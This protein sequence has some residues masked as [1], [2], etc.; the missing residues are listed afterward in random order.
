MYNESMLYNIPVQRG[1]PYCPFMRSMYMIPNMRMRSDDLNDELDMGFPEDID[2]NLNSDLRDDESEDGLQDNRKDNINNEIEEH[3]D[4]SSLEVN[5]DENLFR[6]PVRPDEILRMIE[7]NNPMVIRR[8][9]MHGIP[10]QSAI[11][12]VRRIIYL[13]LQYHK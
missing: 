9:V 13:S 11:N 4:D 7:R 6:S 8:L 12:M 1:V 3:P 5:Y 10:Y 2:D